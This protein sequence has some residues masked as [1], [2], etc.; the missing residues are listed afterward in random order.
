[1]HVGFMGNLFSKLRSE[2]ALKTDRRLRIIN[3]IVNAI[4]VIKMYAWEIPFT[5]MTV[6]ARK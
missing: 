1:M 6:E 3:E 4:R 2:T 5:N